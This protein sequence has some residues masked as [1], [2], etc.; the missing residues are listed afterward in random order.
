MLRVLLQRRD[1]EKILRRGEKICRQRLHS[2]DGASPQE[3][4]NGLAGFESV[5]LKHATITAAGACIV[6]Q[7]RAASQF[8]L[9][10]SLLTS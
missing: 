9:T 6:T 1:W 8:L 10:I 2:Q 7:T 3:K 4:E 5:G